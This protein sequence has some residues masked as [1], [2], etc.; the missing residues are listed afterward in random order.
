MAAESTKDRVL[1]GKEYS[2]MIIKHEK[3]TFYQKTD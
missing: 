1:T 2:V 3:K